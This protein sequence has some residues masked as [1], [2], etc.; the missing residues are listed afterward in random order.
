V[1]KQQ[2]LNVTLVFSCV[3]LCFLNTTRGVYFLFCSGSARFLFFFEVA[4]LI[5]SKVRRRR[6]AVTGGSG[7]FWQ[8][9]CTTA[10]PLFGGLFNRFPWVSETELQA[11]FKAMSDIPF[12]SQ[13][14]D[15]VKGDINSY[16]TV[17]EALCGS[18]AVFRVGAFVLRSSLFLLPTFHLFF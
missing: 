12:L 6:V 7:L 8:Q 9:T 15:L 10:T 11:W 2:K 14:L 16:Q 5:E 18:D 17:V 3:F 4:E 13:K 1:A